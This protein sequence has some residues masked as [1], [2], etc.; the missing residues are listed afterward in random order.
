[1]HVDMGINTAR[2]DEFITSI[3][4][5]YI[6]LN[7]GNACVNVGNFSITDIYV[8]NKVFIWS[9]DSALLYKNIHK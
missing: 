7:A 4:N 1:M 3:K 8:A 2:N 6:L 9:Y 5:N